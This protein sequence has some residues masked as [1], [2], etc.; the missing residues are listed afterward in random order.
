M[1]RSRDGSILLAV[2][3]H[4]FGK[5]DRRK[6]ACAGA[7]HG[8]GAA[9]CDNGDSHP[10]GIAG[11]RPAVVGE[12]VERD[13]DSLIGRQVLR[14]PAA[15]EERDPIA[16]DAGVAHRAQDALGVH[17]AEAAVRR[18]LGGRLRRGR[19]G[20]RGEQEGEREILHLE[21]GSEGEL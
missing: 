6:Y 4:Q 15:G 9:Q 1:A 5:S 3:C 14:H 21:A 10:E 7:P 19:G 13:I 11:R 2:G 20:Q 12:G 18:G 16:R 17:E 8:S